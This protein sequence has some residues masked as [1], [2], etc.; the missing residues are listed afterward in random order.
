MGQLPSTTQEIPH[1]EPTTAGDTDDSDDSDGDGDT[2]QQPT[3]RAKP[4]PGILPD[5][6][7]NNSRAII[8]D[9]GT[10]L[11]SFR[12][13]TGLACAGLW[14]KVPSRGQGNM[15]GFFEPR[16]CVVWPCH[17][18]VARPMSAGRTLWQ[19]A[20]RVHLRP[21]KLKVVDASW[22]QEA[23]TTMR[24]SDLHFHYRPGGEGYKR[25]RDSFERKR[26]RRE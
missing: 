21:K 2:V 17:N 1:N 10:R 8:S 18:Y 16:L 5:F 3:V 19:S 6:C 26:V 14:V 4:A 11:L 9:D 20:C 15:Y 23:D 25:A 22:W 24:A 13:G 12:P 7:Q